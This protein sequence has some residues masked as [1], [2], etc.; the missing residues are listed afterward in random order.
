M[1]VVPTVSVRLKMMRDFLRNTQQEM[2]ARF[3][4]GVNTWSNYERGNTTPSMETLTALAQ[5]GFNP[6][7]MLTGTGSMRTDDET[8]DINTP[9]RSSSPALPKEWP[10]LIPILM[11]SKIIGVMLQAEMDGEDLPLKEIADRVLKIYMKDHELYIN[12]TR[13]IPTSEA[14]TEVIESLRHK[15]DTLF[16]RI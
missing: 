11:K 8:P 14:S 1:E 4:L 9:E 6:M 16:E 15:H 13:K 2:S 12:G 10:P 3:N 5:L 7:W